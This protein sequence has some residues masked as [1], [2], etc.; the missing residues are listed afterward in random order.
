MIL[1]TAFYW[2]LD[3]QTRAFANRFLAKHKRMPTMYQAGV[4]SAATHYLK[5]IQA[6][7]TDEAKSRRCQDARDAGR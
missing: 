3:D 7:G 2:D 4:Y 1:S 5:A 6:V